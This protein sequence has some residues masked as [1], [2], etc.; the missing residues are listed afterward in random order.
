MINE[1]LGMVFERENSGVVRTQF[2]YSKQEVKKW[3]NE[4]QSIGDGINW[5][6][7][8]VQHPD[9]RRRIGYKIGTYIVDEAIKYSGK[10][11]IELTKIKN[12]EIL[13]I[14]RIVL[15]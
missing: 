10:T 12:A 6:H 15:I 14:S 13:K 5:E 8:M 1:G 7:Y 9:G 3:I 4:V 11:V 2:A